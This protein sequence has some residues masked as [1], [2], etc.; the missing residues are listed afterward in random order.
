MNQAQAW[1]YCTGEADQVYLSALYTAT[2]IVRGETGASQE[3]GKNQLRIAVPF[4]NPLARLLASG[5]KLRS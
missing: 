5:Y 4:D 3:F 2:Q 1:R